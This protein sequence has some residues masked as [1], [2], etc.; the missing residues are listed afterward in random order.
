MAADN[1]YSY[2]QGGKSVLHGC[3]LNVPNHEVAHIPIASRRVTRDT[4]E[5][6]A[7]EKYRSCGKGIT[8]ED[9]QRRFSQKKSCSKK[10][11]AFS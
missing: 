1:G 6:I 5:D 7:T 11:E 3:K 4:I 8:F 2:S 9:L 10:P